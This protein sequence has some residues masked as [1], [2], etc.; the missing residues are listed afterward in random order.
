VTR[1][2][3]ALVALALAILA[4]VAMAAGFVHGLYDGRYEA[5]EFRHLDERPKR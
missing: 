5:S 1:V 3:L 4:A 2:R